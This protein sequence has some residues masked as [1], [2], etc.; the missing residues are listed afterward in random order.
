MCFLILCFLDVVKLCPADNDSLNE[1]EKGTLTTPQKD[2]PVTDQDEPT[3]PLEP[4]DQ[5]EP[6]SQSNNPKTYKPITEQDDNEQPD[7]QPKTVDTDKVIDK[8]PADQL[9][10]SCYVCYD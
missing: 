7:D 4:P 10:V 6:T 2:K 1:M 9:V 8:P 5:D 3:G